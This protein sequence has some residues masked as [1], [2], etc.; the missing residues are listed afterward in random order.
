MSA[1]LS[2]TAAPIPLLQPLHYTDF[3]D[4]ADDDHHAAFVVFAQH[5]AAILADQVPLRP[6]HEASA[7]L[8][9]ICR[10]ALD[11]RLPQRKPRLAASLKRISRP[12]ALSRTW[13]EPRPPSPYR[14]G[15]NA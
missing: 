15:P 2:A 6:A 5:A 11:E 4:F 10:H 8:R 7:E 3:P 14:I 1:T 13:R 9:A 12:F